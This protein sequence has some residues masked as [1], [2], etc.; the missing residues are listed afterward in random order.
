LARVRTR[1]EHDSDLEEERLFVTLTSRFGILALVLAS[2][3]MY[4]GVARRQRGM[5]PPSREI[6]RRSP[7]GLGE[8]PASK[9]C[10]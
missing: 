3:G 8:S 9:R 10:A 6:R 5:L 2:V 1:Q 7:V 4:G